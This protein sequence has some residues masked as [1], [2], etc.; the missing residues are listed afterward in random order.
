M[1]VGLVHHTAGVVAQLGHSERVVGLDQDIQRLFKRWHTL[2]VCQCHLCAAN[3]GHIGATLEV[4]ARHMHFILRQRIDDVGHALARVLRVAGFRKARDQFA[5]SFK[6]VFGGFLV[7]LGQVLA[8]DEREQAQVVVEVDQAFQVQ[9]IVQSRACRVQLHEPVERCDGLRFFARLVVGIGLV[10]LRLLGQGGPC[11]TALQ[12]FQQR[13]GLVVGPAVHFVLGF[14]VN[15]IG[16]PARRFIDRGAGAASQQT[17]QQQG[18]NKGQWGTQ[19]R[20][21]L[22]AK[23]KGGAPKGAQGFCCGPVH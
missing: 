18:G 6:G 9:R 5:E 22:S 3:G 17:S 11:S 20:K 7:A 15:A 4:V 21:Q 14:R 16:T 1:W 13:N 2:V 10:D 12:L 19:H 8:R 23:K